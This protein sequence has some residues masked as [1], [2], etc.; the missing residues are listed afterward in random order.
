LKNRIEGQRRRTADFMREGVP[1]LRKAHRTEV[2]TFEWIG[3]IGRALMDQRACECGIVSHLWS[4][5]SRA[6]RIAKIRRAI[7]LARQTA[8]FIAP[9]SVKNL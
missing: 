1:I 6:H 3:Q 2:V 8:A 7:V 9:S 4:A 5:L